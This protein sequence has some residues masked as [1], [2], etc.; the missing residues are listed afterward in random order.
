MKDNDKQEAQTLFQDV[1]SFMNRK[2]KCS[3]KKDFHFQPK[4]VYMKPTLP[5]LIRTSLSP[6]LGLIESCVWKY[7]QGG[8]PK[9]ENFLK[10][11]FLEFWYLNISSQFKVQGDLELSDY[12]INDNFPLCISHSH[13]EARGALTPI[14]KLSTN[15]EAV[16]VCPG[17]WEFFM[18]P[19]K[20]D[21]DCPGGTKPNPRQI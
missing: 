7:E 13:A 21:L 16:L 17:P 11:I 9:V 8:R 1:C 14:D 10:F 3:I 15:S 5:T 2:W 12:L 18:L 4:A 6:S 20:M 19:L